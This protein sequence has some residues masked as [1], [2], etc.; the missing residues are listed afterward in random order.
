MGERG[1]E[2]TPTAPYIRL[3]YVDRFTFHSL[4]QYYTIYY[5]YSA[6]YLCILIYKY[7]CVRVYVYRA[8]PL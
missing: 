6:V 8:I 1:M 7:P 3:L 5:L 2:K 4:V